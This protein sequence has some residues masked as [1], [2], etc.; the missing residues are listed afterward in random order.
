MG[1]VV[2]ETGRDPVAADIG[3]PAVA[4]AVWAAHCSYALESETQ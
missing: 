3:I 2:G 4:T 1:V